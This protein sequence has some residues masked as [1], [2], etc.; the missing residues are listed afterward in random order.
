[1]T[2]LNNIDELALEVRDANSRSYIEEAIRA[3]RAESY[4]SAIIA[5]WIAVSYDLTQKIRELANSGETGVLCR[6]HPVSP[7]YA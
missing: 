5:T 6:K 7:R 3:L 4:R 2:V 1:M